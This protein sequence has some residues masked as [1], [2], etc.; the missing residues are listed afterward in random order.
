MDNKMEEC[1]PEG[2]HQKMDE[3]CWHHNIVYYKLNNKEPPTSGEG[4]KSLYH[5]MVL[6]LCFD[7]VG[8]VGE[9]QYIGAVCKTWE[10]FYLEGHDHEQKQETCFHNSQTSNS[11]LDLW[12]DN[13][14][15]LNNTNHTLSG[16]SSQQR[17]IWI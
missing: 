17:A 8:L 11:C 6:K 15:R 2:K 10:R 12:L 7:F 14:K 1:K 3:I 5:T 9:Y 13:I 4:I 16:T